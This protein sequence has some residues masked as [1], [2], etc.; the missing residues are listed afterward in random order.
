MSASM[1][2]SCECLGG[3]YA[4]I[5]IIIT[6]GTRD[7]NVSQAVYFQVSLE[8]FNVKDA[9]YMNAQIKLIVKDVRISGLQY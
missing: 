5:I 2:E 3:K 6:G 4:K 9:A 8:W 7:K 1:M